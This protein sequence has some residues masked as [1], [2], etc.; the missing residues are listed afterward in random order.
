LTV[1]SSP[2]GSQ[3][4]LLLPLRQLWLPH[5]HLQLKHVHVAAFVCCAV[6]EAVLDAAAI[7]ASLSLIADFPAA[8]PA[9]ATAAAVAVQLVQQLPM[10]CLYCQPACQIHSHVAQQSPPQQQHH[11]PAILPILHYCNAQSAY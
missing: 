10:R 2:E 6:L 8:G 7:A 1:H 5:C 4:L 11:Q 3:L 9:V